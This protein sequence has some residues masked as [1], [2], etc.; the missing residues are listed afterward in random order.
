MYAFVNDSKSVTCITTSSDISTGIDTF[1][2]IIL[3]RVLTVIFWPKIEDISS[4]I[5]C[6]SPVL[7][8]FGVKSSTVRLPSFLTPN[9]PFIYASF[10]NVIV[11]PKLFP[12]P[13]LSWFTNSIYSL[14]LSF[15]ISGCSFSTGCKSLTLIL[16]VTKPLLNAF[17]GST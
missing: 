6:G 2:W 16:R 3:S 4:A 17:F 15:G 10:K 11:L 7:T 13:L 12:L 8:L 14:I 9:L 5:S 1:S